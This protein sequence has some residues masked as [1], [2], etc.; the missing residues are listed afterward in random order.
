MGFRNE[1]IDKLS[2]IWFN[3]P[4]RDTNH[5][6]NRFL[7]AGGVGEKRDNKEIDAVRFGERVVRHKKNR[8]KRK[9]KCEERTRHHKDENDEREETKAGFP[10]FL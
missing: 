3:Q 1:N 9:D 5:F 4:A 7:F 8:K 2:S 6:W 10:N